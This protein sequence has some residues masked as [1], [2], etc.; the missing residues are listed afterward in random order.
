MGLDLKDK[1][2]TGLYVYGYLQDGD[3]NWIGEKILKDLTVN[4]Q[5]DK[6]TVTIIMSLCNFED[7]KDDN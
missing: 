6:G 4:V 1:I 7:I 2:A 5:R 3:T